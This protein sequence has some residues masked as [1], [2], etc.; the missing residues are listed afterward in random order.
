MNRKKI[1]ILVIGS[2]LLGLA[3]LRETGVVDAN[4]YK[5]NLTA[6]QS[7]TKGD[8]Y[9]GA[10]K[11]F[12]YHLTIKHK[13]QTLQSQTFSYNNLLPIEIEATLDDPVYSGNCILPLIKNFKM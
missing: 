1:A 8:T 12:S 7:A 3:V 9:S 5:S 4:L 13:N 10:E 11:H 6:S 2:V